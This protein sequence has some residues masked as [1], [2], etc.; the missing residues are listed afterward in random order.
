MSPFSKALGIR[1]CPILRIDVRVAASSTGSEVDKLC[2]LRIAQ[3]GMAFEG[4][5]STNFLRFELSQ[6]NLEG[7]E[8]V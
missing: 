6:H 4:F 8:K 1:P 3:G 2:A 7:F 5:G